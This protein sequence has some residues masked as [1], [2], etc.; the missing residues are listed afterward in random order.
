MSGSNNGLLERVSRGNAQSNHSLGCALR[1]DRARR[2]EIG[3]FTATRR[4]R[5]EE[6]A[7]VE[8]ARVARPAPTD[9]LLAAIAHE[10]TQPLTAVVTN[11]NACLHWLEHDPPNLDEAREAAKRI[12]K[13]GYCASA[14]AE[15]IRS[16]VGKG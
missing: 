15:S 6:A 8:V 7:Q 11:A 4:K 12:L 10:I 14:M 9:K 13:D 16:L 3:D 1:L 2:D 5:T